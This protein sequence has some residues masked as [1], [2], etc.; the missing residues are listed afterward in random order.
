MNQ[1]FE[2]TGTENGPE[3]GIDVNKANFFAEFAE[4][5]E[6]T[7]ADRMAFLSA[8]TMRPK[9]LESEESKAKIAQLAADL[10]AFYHELYNSEREKMTPFPVAIRSGL[11]D[12]VDAIDARDWETFSKLVPMLDQNFQTMASTLE[13]IRQSVQFAE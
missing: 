11:S 8:G 9:N 2:T 4:R 6:K 5:Y 13:A 3:R 1:S 12:A 7:L 10:K